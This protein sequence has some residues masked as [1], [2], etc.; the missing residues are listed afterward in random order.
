MN[1]N[2][3]AKLVTFKS[4]GLL[5]IYIF[6]VSAQKINFYFVEMAQGGISMIKS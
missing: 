6:H 4:L 1:S 2:Y 3:H 5:Y